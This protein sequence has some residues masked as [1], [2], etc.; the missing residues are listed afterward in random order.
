MDESLFDE[1]L[2]VKRELFATLINSH[3]RL[4]RVTE[5]VNCPTSLTA[6]QDKRASSHKS[7]HDQNIIIATAEQ[8]P[9]LFL[10]KIIL[11]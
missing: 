10:R 7:V 4:T 11:A 5:N 8:Q 6:S 3:S 2:A 1:E 9:H